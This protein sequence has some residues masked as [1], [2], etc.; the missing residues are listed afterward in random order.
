MPLSTQEEQG[1]VHLS[2]VFLSLRK[3]PLEHFVQEVRFLD[4]QAIQF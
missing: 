1:E 3:N 4:V 2:Q